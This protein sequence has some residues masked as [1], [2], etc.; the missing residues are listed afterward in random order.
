[1]PQHMWHSRLLE[2]LNAEL[3]GNRR[4]ALLVFL[5]FHGVG[6]GSSVFFRQ[7]YGDDGFHVVAGATHSLDFR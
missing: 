4:R 1:M 5:S 3:S 6:S 2:F 7:E